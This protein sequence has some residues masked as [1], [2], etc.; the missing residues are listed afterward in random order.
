MG[1][2]V[3]QTQDEIESNVEQKCQTTKTIGQIKMATQNLYDRCQ[4]ISKNHKKV[5]LGCSGGE[6][7]PTSGPVSPGGFSAWWYLGSLGLSARHDWPIPI[8]THHSRPHA[9]WAWRSRCPIRKPAALAFCLR[10]R[11]C[12][13]CGSWGLLLWVVAGTAAL[14]PLLLL[15]CCVV[16]TAAFSC[17]AV[18]MAPQMSEPSSRQNTSK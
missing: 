2:A 9:D 7:C 5:C 12:A 3:V 17:F 11:H 8:L 6:R 4:D 15:F 14:L 18:K 16:V 13:P 1:K 10:I